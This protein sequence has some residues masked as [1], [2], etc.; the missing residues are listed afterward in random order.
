MIV[1]CIKK[2]L[3]KE[4]NGENR[5]RA[6]R[7]IPAFVVMRLFVF[8]RKCFQQLAHDTVSD[9]ILFRGQTLQPFCQIGYIILR[10]IWE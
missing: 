6:G 5:E 3:E 4:S 9:F 7:K 8:K 2:W 1:G 10:C